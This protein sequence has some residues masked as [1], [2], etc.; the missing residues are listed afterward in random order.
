MDVSNDARVLEVGKGL[1]NEGASGM[2]GVE[3]VVVG[4]FWTG[5]VKIGGREGSCME[6]KGVNNTTFIASPHKSGLISYWLVGDI[7]GRLGLAKLV[8]KDKWVVPKVS[9]IEFLPA[10]T[11]MVSVSKGCERVACAGNGNGTGGKAAMN[12][13]GR[14][15]SEWLFFVHVAKKDISKGGNVEEVEDVMVLLDVDIEGF[16]LKSLISKYHDGREETVCPSVKGL[17]QK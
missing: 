8:N 11:R 10:F 12:D 3:N 7:L 14:R 13:R 17:G 5:T 16:V 6:G 4:V 9:C 15:A 1:V 2:G